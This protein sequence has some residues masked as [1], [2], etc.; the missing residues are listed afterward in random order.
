MKKRFS[1]FFIITC[2]L[3]SLIQISYA[4]D[5]QAK[6]SQWITVEN[7]EVHFEMPANWEFFNDF[8]SIPLLVKSPKRDQGRVVI[9]VTPFNIDNI[10]F[11]HDEIER[12]QKL[13]RKGREKWLSEVHG[14]SIDYFPYQVEKWEKAKEVQRIGFSFL[15]NNIAYSEHSY[16]VNCR[17]HIFHLKALYRHDDYLK[18]QHEIQNI[19][20]TFD[21]RPPETSPGS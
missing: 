21:C 1:I 17:D 8:I 20:K 3:G 5:W 4:S 15:L 9:S 6:K 13:Y 19:I 10:E 11:D 7:Y 2:I 12:N 14:E 18:D 16:Y